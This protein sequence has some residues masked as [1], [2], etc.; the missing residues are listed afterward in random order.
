MKNLNIAFEVLSDPEKRNQ[1]D[2]TNF[3]FVE[4]KDIQIKVLKTKRILIITVVTMIA[5]NGMKTD[6]HPPILLL[7]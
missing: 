4:N 3:N 5:L 7:P 6:L 2:N 1:Y